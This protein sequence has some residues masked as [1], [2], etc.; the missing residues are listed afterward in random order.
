MNNSII[1]MGNEEVVPEEKE[2]KPLTEA[3]IPQLVGQ[4]AELVKSHFQ[5]QIDTILHE[6]NIAQDDIKGL[7]AKLSK[8]EI[9]TTQLHKDLWSHTHQQT[10]I[11]P[12]HQ[13]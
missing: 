1:D 4:I 10:G 2:P 12:P 11:V 3:D 13:G 6:L 7:N 8:E 9:F 5:G